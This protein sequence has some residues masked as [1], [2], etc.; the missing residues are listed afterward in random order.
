MTKAFYSLI[1]FCPDVGRQETF[2]VGLVL[3]RPAPHLV[4]VRL[5]EG[6]GVNAPNDLGLDPDLF[7]ATKRAF[8]NRLV[9]EARR[10]RGAEDLT[11]FKASGTN[12]LRLT[13]P[14]EVSLHDPVADPQALFDELVGSDRPSVAKRIAR[15][16]RVRTRLRDALKKRE[17]LPFV[18]ERVR[19]MVPAL[20]TTLEVPFAYQNG[21]YNLIEPVD[22]S[23]RDEV[24]R[25]ER[26]AWYA[27][28][29]KSI[30]DVPD[31]QHGD[32]Q[33]VVVARLPD[34]PTAARKVSD[35]LRDNRV[36]CVPLADP[37]LDALASEI[38]AHAALHRA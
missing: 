18:E 10:F 29:G 30:F 31:T 8:R 3:F 12:P 32:R 6:F 14:R 11:F 13:A 9:D 38:R 26:T 17:V 33:L 22:F 27:L 7:E 1:Q 19:V 24:V 34:E 28:G 21:R 4:D 16:P 5:A 25:Q 36:N 35:V 15:G 2:N 37:D 23:M 20:R